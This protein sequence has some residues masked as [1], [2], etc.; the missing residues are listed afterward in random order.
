MTTHTPEERKAFDQARDTARAIQSLA[1]SG[2]RAADA[3]ET[4]AGHLDTTKH[5]RLA[6]A[7]EGVGEIIDQH[8]TN[9]GH[10]L[11]DVVKAIEETP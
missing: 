5:D 1:E 3:L 2:K 10:H 9:L 7:V 8:D 6:V 11:G 4:I